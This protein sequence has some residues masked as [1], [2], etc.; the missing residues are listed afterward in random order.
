MRRGIGTVYG[1]GAALHTTC[2]ETVGD[3]RRQACTI[4]R[5]GT[6]Q[7]QVMGGAD[8]RIEIRTQGGL[9]ACKDDNGPANLGEGGNQLKRLFR[10]EL[11][12]IGFRMSLG[13]AVTAGEI[14]GAGNFPGNQSAKRTS[15]FQGSCSAG[16]LRLVDHVHR[17]SLFSSRYSE[18]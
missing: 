18:K 13:P 10:G 12:G 15:V 6:D 5:T 1:Y 3:L 2:L 8:E 14:A 11:P 4:G 16:S 9:T 7:T 17:T